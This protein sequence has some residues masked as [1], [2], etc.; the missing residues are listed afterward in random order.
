M[1]RWNWSI[2]A[3]A[4]VVCVACGATAPAPAPETQA[5]PPVMIEISAD[6]TLVEPLP[7]EVKVG[8]FVVFVGESA[9]WQIR[10]STPEIIAV[11]Q[12]GDQ[13]TYATN[14]GGQTLAAG[15][16]VIE[17]THPNHAN[18]SV[19]LTVVDR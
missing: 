13:G 9:D 2:W 18:L 8:D 16:A 5:L 19:T 1:K 15:T 14:P 11:Q 10:T 17:L 4:L 6:G 3:I 12:G 7:S